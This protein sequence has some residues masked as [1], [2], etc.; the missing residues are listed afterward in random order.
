MANSGHGVRVVRECASGLY[1]R[2]AGRRGARRRALRVER[3]GGIRAEV[4]VVEGD[5]VRVS[6]G[7]IAPR[8]A[9]PKLSRIL[10]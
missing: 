9:A 8:F 4:H 1:G 2:E 7:W 3:G 10:C 6:G 5:A